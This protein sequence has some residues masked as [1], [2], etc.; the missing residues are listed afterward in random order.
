[1]AGG[2]VVV[3]EF[4]AAGIVGIV[5]VTEVVLVVDEDTVESVGIKLFATTGAATTGT[6]ST[7]SGAKG[8]GLPS[9]PSETNSIVE[10][11]SE[12]KTGS[13]KIASSI[14]MFLTFNNTVRKSL[15]IAEVLSCVS[16]T[17]VVVVFKVPVVETRAGVSGLFLKK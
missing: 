5:G 17:E 6:L 13:A 2:V 14:F 12:R 16:E 15:L 11:L 1:V 3:L 10:S 4:E 9:F 8:F 7:P